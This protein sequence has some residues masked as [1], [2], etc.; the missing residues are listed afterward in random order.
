M[1]AKEKLKLIAK[2]IKDSSINGLINLFKYK[3]DLIFK[4]DKILAKPISLQLEPTTRCN[5]KC[6][7]CE[8]SFD[9]LHKQNLNYNQFK[10][11][12]NQF[13]FLKNIILQ[14]LGEP[15]LNQE[16]FLMIK[17]VKLR[18]IRVGL[19]TNATLL[20]R[21]MAQKI[22]DSE[23]DWIYISL[24]AV[25][26]EKYE[27]I[28][29]GANYTVV[30]ENIKNFLKLK[31]EQ[32]PNVGFWT[33]I[34]KENLFEIPKV[35]QLASKLG[36]KKVVLQNI[37][38][39]GYEN[40]SRNIDKL[41]CNSKQELIKLVDKIRG[42][43]AGVKVEI[44]T[45]MRDGNEKCDWPWRSLYIT[46]DGYI[47]PC[48]MQGS[49]P[50]VINFGNVFKEHVESIINNEKYQKFRNELKG[51]SIPEICH[52]CPAYYRQKVIKI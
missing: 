40:F 23:V 9:Q 52:G 13:P 2:I 12:I 15:L 35:V 30:M 24:D 43:A 44:N 3:Y 17:E 39:W 7:M 47:T 28:R 10:Q 27:E 18:N 49:D 41:K 36:I 14:G 37:H 46:C 42:V 32:L 16:L 11:I 31:G 34:M 8:H 38:N 19:T 51:K 22:V 50:R 48:C 45:N 6:K 4:K 1:N 21:E 20:N 25:D 26:K 33:L 5:L 29:K